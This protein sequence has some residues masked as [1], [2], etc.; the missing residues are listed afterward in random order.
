MIKELYAIR[1][2]IAQIGWQLESWTFNQDDLAVLRFLKFIDDDNSRRLE[3]MVDGDDLRD[4]EFIVR[5]NKLL[6]SVEAMNDG[7]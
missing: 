1:N 4:D 3:L 5:L 2:G 7:Q 6:K